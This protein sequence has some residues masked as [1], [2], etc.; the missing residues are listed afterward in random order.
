MVK[1]EIQNIVPYNKVYYIDCICLSFF[2]AVSYFKSSVFSYM[3]NDYLVYNLG[4]T[5]NGLSLSLDNLQVQSFE[6]VTKNN[7]I[8]IEYGKGYY[9]DIVNRVI[10]SILK[11]YIII[12][13]V[14]GFYY[15]H[16]YH[17][18]FYQKEHHAYH[19]L[20]YGF[21]TERK[22][23]KTVE[24]N[25]LEWNTGKCCY[26]YEMSFQDMV[27]GHEGIINHVPGGPTLMKLS[28]NSSLDT[29]SD[30]PF[31]FRGSMIDNMI[32][33]KTEILTGLQNI[34]TLSENIGE[35]D[36]P[37]STAFSNKVAS[38]SNQYKINSIIGED[39]NCGR[40]FT[41]IIESWVAIEA[42]M[43]MN[44]IKGVSEKKKFASKLG[45]LYELECK[46][47]EN[48]FSLFDKIQPV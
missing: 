24:V 10:D 39:H 7:G 8:V 18:L 33:H 41:D 26:R 22:I 25:G 23:F 37:K 28:R 9:N 46:L 48:L 35:F 12:L 45:R 21:E 34:L 17:D 42:L 6:E 36:I 3:A 32:S 47:Y 27:L 2:T 19:I 15:K 30:D 31:S 43:F 5:E 4:K 16:P 1:Y 38:L 13:T 14:D 29:I 40:L 44:D 11:G 20:V